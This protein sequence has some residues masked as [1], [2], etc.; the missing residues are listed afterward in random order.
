MTN[1]PAEKPNRPTEAANRPTNKP[2]RPDK[3]AQPSQDVL[4]GRLKESLGTIRSLRARVQELQQP[5][6]LAVIGLSCRLPGGGTP[7]EFWESLADGRDATSEFPE[8]RHP[9][10]GFYHPD[11]DHPGTAYTLAGNFLDGPVDT[12]DPTVFGI[13]PREAAGMDPQQRLVLELAWEAMEDACLP[14]ADL[15]GNQVGV[16]LGASTSDYVRMRQQEGAI[17]D[18]DAYQL[19]GEP[20]FLA[21]RISYTFGFQGPSMVIDTACSSSLVALEQACLSLRSGACDMALVGGVNLML[22]PY[23]FVL[24]SKLRAL[25]PDGRCKTFDASA[26]GY[27]R[28]EGGALFV[29]KRLSEAEAAGDRILAVVRGVATEHDGRSSGLTVPNPSAQ[30][31][32]ISSALKDAGAAPAELSYVEAH[33]TGTP[34]GDPIE[35]KALDAITRTDRP[36][37]RPLLVGSVKTNIGHLEPAAGAAGILKVVLALKHDT[38]PRHLHLNNPNPQVPWSDLHL[39]VTTEETRWPAGPRL[40]GVSSFGASGTNAHTV[41]GEAPKP[42]PRG[43]TT[44]DTGL[45]TLSANSLPALRAMATSYEARVRDADPRTL[46]DIC[47]TTHI[48]RARMKHGISVSGTRE[49]LVAGLAAFAAGERAEQVTVHAPTGAKARRLGWLFTGQGSQYAGMASELAASEPVFA[50]AL[51]EC[52]AAL[53]PYLE[54]PLGPVLEGTGGGDVNR[55]NRTG[56]TQPALFAVEYALARMWESWGVRPSALIGHSLGEI[57]AACVAGVH[58]LQ[59]AAKLITARARLMEALPA[60]GVME[61]L[62]CDEETVR[63]AIA[64]AGRANDVSVAAVNGPTDVVLSGPVAE[65]GEVVELL[66]AQG[67]KHRPLAVS[68][69]FHSPLMAPMLAEFRAV[70]ETLTFHQPTYPIISNVTGKEWGPEQL[71]PQYWSEHVM[72]PVRFAEGITTLYE[73]GCRTF[74][75][76]GPAPILL[77]L[78][79]RSLPEDGVCWIPSLRRD[80][81]DGHIVAQALGA[82]HHRGV[83]VD[84]AA[85]H[86]AEEPRRSALPSYPWQ[87]ERYWFNEDGPGGA[88]PAATTPDDSPGAFFDGHLLSGQPTFSPE[89]DELPTEFVQTGQDGRRS[90]SAGGFCNWALT[91]AAKLPGAQPRVVDRFVVGEPLLLDAEHR[92][93]QVR[94]YVLPQDDEGRS[95]FLCF[96]LQGGASVE[97]GSW[98]L[99]ARGVLARRTPDARPGGGDLA[100]VRAR[101]LPVAPADVT[102]PGWAE[103]VLNEVYQGPGEVLAEVNSAA[104]QLPRGALLD[105][106]IGLLRQSAHVGEAAEAKTPK[107]PPV[108]V[109][110]YIHGWLDPED[111]EA[112]DGDLRGGLEIL[113]ADGSPLIMMRHVHLHSSSA[114][115]DDLPRSPREDTVWEQVWQPVDP[116]ATAGERELRGQRVLLLG[117]GADSVRSGIVAETTGQL[118][119]RGALVTH[120]EASVD[121]ARAALAAGSAEGS[122]DH[123]VLLSGLDLPV[124]GYDSS[125]IQQ[126]RERAEYV[127]LAAVKQL[128]TEESATRVWVVTRGAQFTGSGQSE[129]CLPAGPLWGLGKVAA[130]EHPELWGGLLDLDPAGSPDEAA[131]IAALLATETAEDL[132]ARRAGALLVP[133]LVPAPVAESAAERPVPQLSDLG[134]YL[135]TGGLGSLGLL[136]GEWLASLGAG[137]VVLVGRGGLPDRSAWDAPELDDATA[138]K[139]AGVRRIEALGADVRVVA[140]DVSDETALRSLT[141]Q[142]GLAGRP[143]RGAVHAAGLS[144]PQFLRESDPETYDRVMHAKA[145]GTWALHNA[146][147]D[148][149]L[150]L[151]VCFSSIASV[152]GSQHLAGYSAANAFLDSFAYYRKLRGL[153]ATTVSW[154]PWGARSGLADDS[155]MAFLR[156]IGLHQL[157][158]A[159]ALELLGEAMVDGVANRT[160]CSADWA[161][162]RDLMEARRERPILSGIRSAPAAGASGGGAEPGS[163]TARLLGLPRDERLA[164]INEYVRVQL[165]GILRMELDTLTAD[166]RLA[167]M[168]LDSLM[169][170][171]LISRCR[172][173]LGLEINSRDFFACPGIDWGSFLHELIEEKYPVADPSAPQRQAATA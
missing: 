106:T 84:W 83:P 26:N 42:A 162:F 115:L 100:A 79:A 165:S 64:D 129:I 47:Y 96:S 69:A 87:R 126:A 148:Q 5:Q 4:R 82:L 59:D 75:E 142:L 139:I 23:G 2:D 80:R 160:V 58:S 101:C 168:G 21:G 56:F 22:S 8:E 81:E 44:R 63:A 72:A 172:D 30:Q 73:T 98:R 158:P 131:Q 163:L 155:V 153:N 97:A 108:G 33:G 66:A 62:V 74:L 134:S 36:A 120:A 149:N 68:H 107:A 143:L 105:L 78:G 25:S 27:A 20:S 17:A 110:R 7:E 109:R 102:V 37:D 76:L 173:D 123:L 50:A 55:I 13:S 113:G 114:D 170:M 121:T 127:F 77:G 112:Q 111:P 116:A 38:L 141:D 164:E 103:P 156:S 130:L 122:Y 19:I 132:T 67:V 89:L 118:A 137:T 46:A 14:P 71:R 136:V 10:A 53:D 28:G 57:T 150:D 140:L 45:L 51:A 94:V 54:E 11:P 88:S 152:W 70:T 166:T 86:R 147:V 24:V 1:N 16:F 117:G 65:V 9:V 85:V 159:H 124:A 145:A 41:I 3:P 95:L 119:L 40:A 60:G 39:K 35:L 34:L 90:V 52:V 135:V 15:E 138:A 18:V 144:E 99:H 32:V 157:N 49:Q 61:T 29:L 151:F 171:E 154:G 161:L 104:E 31:S 133:R 146:T 48:G 169:V 92:P 91:G 125:A 12:F 128:A 93:G 6:P 43:G 167:D